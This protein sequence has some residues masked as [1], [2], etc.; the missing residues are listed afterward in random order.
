MADASDALQRLLDGN[1]RYVAGRSTHPNQGTERRAQVVSGQNPF[2]VILGCSDSRVPPEILFDQ[3]I[4]DL[5]I[6]RVA[7]N[8][9]DPTVLGSIEYAVEHLSVP[10][11]IVLGHAKC[12]AVQA[13]VKGGTAE[14]HVQVLIKAIQPAVEKAAAENGGDMVEKTVIEN[15]SLVVSQ[16]KSSPP[17]LSKMVGDGR[18]KVVGARYDLES[19][20]VEVVG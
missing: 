11:V 2:A 15:V 10:L 14:G 7:G 19:G 16:I 3:G 8:I 20:R 9:A 1:G 17:I 6:I 13:A 4:G 12:G 5:F 18:V